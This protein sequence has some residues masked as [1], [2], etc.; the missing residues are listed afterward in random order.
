MTR[1][2]LTTM[3]STTAVAAVVGGCL[4]LG[5]TPQAQA[6]TTIGNC[7]T[8]CVNIG[9]GTITGSSGGNIASVNFITRMACALSAGSTT[10]TCKSF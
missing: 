6:A 2:M 7:A 3:G 9:T 4:L 10:P 1:R 8:G 5:P